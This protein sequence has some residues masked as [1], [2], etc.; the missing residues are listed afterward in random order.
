M[1]TEHKKETS[2]WFEE[3]AKKWQEMEWGERQYWLAQA[4]EE[5]RLPKMKFIMTYRHFNFDKVLDEYQ[6]F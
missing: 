4:A 6:K 1:E 2:P 5:N 3:A